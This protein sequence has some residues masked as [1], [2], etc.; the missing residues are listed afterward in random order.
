MLKGF[1]SRIV[2]A[3][4]DACGEYYMYDDAQNNGCPLCGS[5]SR[6]LVR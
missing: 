4:C 5:K 3:I 6:S 2:A 1:I